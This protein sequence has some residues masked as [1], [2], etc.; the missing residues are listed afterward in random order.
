V[1]PVAISAL[2]SC[3]G[4]GDVGQWAWVNNGVAIPTYHQGV[5]TTGSGQWPVICAYNASIYGW[6]Y[7]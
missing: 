4:V 2:P 3:A 6:V 7:D 5:T 1:T